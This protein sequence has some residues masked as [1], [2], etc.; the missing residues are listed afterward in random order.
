MTSLWQDGHNA[1]DA[2]ENDSDADESG[3]TGG[4]THPNQ[5]SRARQDDHDSDDNN[6]D[7]TSKRL[8]R[9]RRD[10]HPADSGPSRTHSNQRSWAHQD[11]RDSDNSDNDMTS[12]KRLHRRGRQDNHPD[13]QARPSRTY[14]KKRSRARQDDCDSDDNNVD[15]VASKRLRQERQ[16]HHPDSGH[17]RTQSKKRSRACQ[18][19]RD[20]DDNFVNDGTDRDSDSPER[21][22]IMVPGGATGR[23]T[24]KRT[25]LPPKF[26]TRTVQAVDERVPDEHDSDE[27]DSNDSEHDS[28]DEHETKLTICPEEN[29]NH[30]IPENPSRTLV[31]MIQRAERLIQLPGGRDSVAFARLSIEICNAL[32]KVHAREEHVKSSIREG[33][34]LEFAWEELPGRVMQMKKDIL[35][36]LHHP[37]AR[38]KCLVH[39]LFIKELEKAGLGRDYVKLSKGPAPMALYHI[40]QPG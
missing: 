40:A 8:H 19:D 17:S 37:S 29:C 10:N 34:P 2:S 21:L 13:S 35:D 25:S 23:S 22:T 5:R 30:V 33:W 9:G 28:A 14:S 1:N 36:L 11:D 7:V 38:N 4:R 26:K 31:L 24:Q 16:D 27:H 6:D 39:T 12:L 15:N 3:P 18:D 20:S 32:R